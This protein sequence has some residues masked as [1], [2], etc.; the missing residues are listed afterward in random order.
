MLFKNLK[1]FKKTKVF[2]IVATT[3]VVMAFRPFALS[4]AMVIRVKYVATQIE[5]AFI[6][7]CTQIRA[8]VIQ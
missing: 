5:I 7:R 4:N 2:A 3:L 1:I 6:A 8:L